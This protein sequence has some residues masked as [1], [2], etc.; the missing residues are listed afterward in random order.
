MNG[1]GDNIQPN[2][3]GKYN[4]VREKEGRK[5]RWDFNNGPSHQSPTQTKGRA[6]GGSETLKDE[7]PSHQII[8]RGG[9][10]ST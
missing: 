5:Q 10:I 1:G 2:T 3:P 8:G 4:G 9:N 7:N 6:E